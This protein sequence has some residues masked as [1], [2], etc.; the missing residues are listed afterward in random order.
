[1]ASKTVSVNFRGGSLQGEG[2]TACYEEEWTWD[3]VVADAGAALGKTVSQPTIITR[4]VL[5]GKADYRTLT[6]GSEIWDG[7]NEVDVAMSIEVHD[8]TE[9]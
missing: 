1:M 3:E 5:A 6:G 2:H 7:V 4:N 9:R 8:Y